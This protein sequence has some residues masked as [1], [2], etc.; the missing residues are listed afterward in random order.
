MRKKRVIS[1]ALAAVFILCMPV[2]AAETEPTVLVDSDLAT[3]D[4]I[5]SMSGFESV[6]WASARC[7]YSSAR[8]IYTNNTAG[9]FMTFDAGNGTVFTAAQFRVTAHAS[10]AWLITDEGQLDDMLLWSEDGAAWAPVGAGTYTE[11]G[12]N[13]DGATAYYTYQVAWELPDAARYLKLDGTGFAGFQL[14]VHHAT[15]SGNI[16]SEGGGEEP[17]PPSLEADSTF[18]DPC[19]TLL[20]PENDEVTSVYGDMQS[21]NWEWYWMSE[22]ERT[23]LTSAG[24]DADDYLQY[25]LKNGA[26][27]FVYVEWEMLERNDATA[28][29]MVS[30]SRNG[31][32]WSE[33][34]NAVKVSSV[35]IDDPT[36]WQFKRVRYQ[37][38]LPE[39]MKQVNINLTGITYRMCNVTLGMSKAVYPMDFIQ[40]S[41]APEGA[42]QNGTWTV[43]GELQN[44][45]NAATASAILLGI[46][47]DGVM[48]DLEVL[49]LSLQPG[50][51]PFTICADAGDAAT[52]STA[53]LY[54]WTSE[55]G[56]V[57]IITT[58][59]SFPVLPAA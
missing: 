45:G 34:V 40:Y 10:S 38:V 55:D 9:S 51:N 12:T 2:F 56:M 30:A 47:K 24:T 39:G 52:D 23:F 25:T 18:T 54:V 21:V 32:I 5:A 15:L 43:S 49:P 28:V 22:T 19:E 7:G 14:F 58:P 4:D 17:E 13:Y 35:S 53:I 33:P 8:N 3:A 11:E 46:Y 57:P 41:T 48:L 42:F 37:C 16:T 50:L 20:L 29:P 6:S 1:L 27:D 36:A 59:V 26:N 44:S 31:V